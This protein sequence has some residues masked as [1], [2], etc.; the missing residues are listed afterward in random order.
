MTMLTTLKNYQAWRTGQDERT[1]D[2]IGLT[3]KKISEA[4]EWAIDKL[5]SME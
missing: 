4:L 1:L 2:E 3:P 5:E